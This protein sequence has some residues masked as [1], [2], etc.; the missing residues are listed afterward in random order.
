MEF[1]TQKYSKRISEFLTEYEKFSN[2]A[3]EYES[4]LA[5][6]NEVLR[7]VMN[8]QKNLGTETLLKNKNDGL[9]YILSKEN[10]LMHVKNDINLTL[11]DS[12]SYQTIDIDLKQYENNIIAE[13]VNGIDGV[14]YKSNGHDASIIGDGLTNTIAQVGLEDLSFSNTDNFAL[15]KVSSSM[16]AALDTNSSSSVCLLEDA[17]KCESYAKMKNNLHYGV[18]ENNVNNKCECYIFE[19]INTLKNADSVIN[20]YIVES[21]NTNE[22]QYMGILFD[23]GLYGLKE[24]TYSN[25]FNGS[26]VPNEDNMVS[27]VASSDIMGK[28]LSCNPFTGH[29]PYD[30]VPNSFDQNGICDT[31]NSDYDSMYTQTNI[32]VS[33]PTYL[34]VCSTYENKTTNMFTYDYKFGIDNTNFDDTF[35]S[36]IGNK[37]TRIYLNTSNDLMTCNNSDGSEVNPSIDVNYKVNGSS[38]QISSTTY[39]SDFMSSVCSSSP[40][41]NCDISNA[42]MFLDSSYNMSSNN[43]ELLY[44]K[45][46]IEYEVDGTSYN[47]SF[48]LY[49]DD[50]SNSIYQDSLSEFNVS[51]DVKYEMKL[52]SN[53][54]TIELLTRNTLSDSEENITGNMALYST[55]NKIRL[56]I[57]KDD[58]LLK[59]QTKDINSSTLSSTTFKYGTYD[60]S[61]NDIILPI[62]TLNDEEKNKVGSNFYRMGYIGYDNT[63]KLISN[64][65]NIIRN[66]GVNYENYPYYSHNDIQNLVE[67]S[68][69]TVDASC[70]E[71]N[72]CLGYIS[73]DVTGTNIYYKISKD[74]IHGIYSGDSTYT[75]NYAFNLKKNG[76][77]VNDMYLLNSDLTNVYD[78]ASFKSFKE[79]NNNNTIFV[80][81]IIKENQTE[82]N[83][84]KAKFMESYINIITLFERLSESEIEI[85]RQTG[86]KSNE[87][88]DVLKRYTA[89]YK[90]I[91]KKKEKRQNL[92][93]ENNDYMIL[94]NRT[95]LHMAAAGL[96]TLLSLLALF[97]I[98]RR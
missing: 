60:N 4:K 62:N 32:N 81:N 10:V 13:D 48:T 79:T 84:S 98:M 8:N 50:G 95:K 53:T 96:G 66:N 92:E 77:K 9:F 17:Y 74:E 21:S 38:Q 87:I 63:I 33:D 67:Y 44:I 40:V 1:N 22:L 82:L 58:G 75:S 20:S 59:I 49:N 83:E 80:D 86:T 14:F 12:S 88:S 31:K 94:N 69:T 35:Y 34:N 3:N 72:D 85:L 39:G 68:G 76:V 93:I 36:Y 91:N 28:Q 23:G 42:R 30:I 26:F 29:G 16:A 47:S 6:F 27:L 97:R 52:D 25:N 56:I 2:I 43:G 41:T 73:Q 65:D 45:L 19:N 54:S 51:S 46:M 57:G 89:I 70:A 55:D 11:S 64:D 71:D 18:L 24:K 61:S 15:K 78:I 5:D 37:F 7:N 90:N